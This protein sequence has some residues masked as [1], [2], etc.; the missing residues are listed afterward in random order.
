MAMGCESPEF[1]KPEDCNWRSKRVSFHANSLLRNP[2]I[3]Q[4]FLFQLRVCL[5]ELRSSVG[6]I[7]RLLWRIQT[8]K[9]Y[10]SAAI[11]DP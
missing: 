11:T 9:L 5:A 4:G 6:K 3:E 8:L 7:E 10:E 1:N 2:V